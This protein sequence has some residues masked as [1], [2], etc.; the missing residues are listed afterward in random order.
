VHPIIGLLF[1][2]L[3]DNLDLGEINIK[4]ELKR[5]FKYYRDDPIWDEGISQLL[6]TTD[7]WW[8]DLGM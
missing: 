5:N 8:E 4:N 3:R 1:F 7:R 6:P 2:A